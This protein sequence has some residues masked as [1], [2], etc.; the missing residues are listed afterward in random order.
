LL[1]ATPDPL[2]AGSGEGGKRRHRFK[3]RVN[4]EL[5]H[6]SESRI[7]LKGSCNENPAREGI[8]RGCEIWREAGMVV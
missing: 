1:V 6:L 3:A 4:G 8:E 7:M 2:A 5:L